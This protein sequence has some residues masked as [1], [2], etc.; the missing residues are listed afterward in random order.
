MCALPKLWAPPTRQP[1]CHP[2]S[3]LKPSQWLLFSV[4]MLEGEKD[5]FFPISHCQP[6]FP[7]T[8]LS[9][10]FF[11][12]PCPSPFFRNGSFWVPHS[13][14]LDHSDLGFPPPPHQAAGVWAGTRI[15][16]SSQWPRLLWGWGRWGVAAHFPARDRMP[17]QRGWQ[18]RLPQRPGRKEVS[19]FW[20]RGSEPGRWVSELEATWM[21]LGRTS[22]H[23]SNL[24]ILI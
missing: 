12:E 7:P 5:H 21:Q 23:H 8:A 13:E 4:F 19:S 24:H 10:S 3:D 20:S 14:A 17:Q 16:S 18:W 9:C 1:D 6:S 11:P 22:P 2:F 15:D